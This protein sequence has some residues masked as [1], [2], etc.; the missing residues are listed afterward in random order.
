MGFVAGDLLHDVK[1]V[2]G[3]EEVAE[4]ED[5]DGFLW[6]RSRGI[7]KLINFRACRT[8][9][10]T[11]DSPFRGEAAN[12]AAIGVQ[13][14]TMTGDRRRDS[15]TLTFSVTISRLLSSQRIVR[16]CAAEMEETMKHQCLASFNR[17]KSMA[18]H[19][20]QILTV[21]PLRHSLVD[22]LMGKHLQDQRQVIRVK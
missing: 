22:V 4:G 7:T 13:V 17:R 1:V 15:F 9:Q 12:S 11:R 20:R 5:R 21:I 3:R 10:D 6:Q 2:D 14:G 16:V 8:V 19:L 18:F